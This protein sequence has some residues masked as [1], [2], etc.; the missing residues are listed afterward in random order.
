[1]P[2]LVLAATLNLHL[3][4][5]A[6]S[7]PAL[8]YLLPPTIFAPSRTRVWP[9]S[10]NFLLASPLRHDLPPRSKHLHDIPAVP[11]FSALEHSSLH[12]VAAESRHPIKLS[13]HIRLYSTMV[14]MGLDGV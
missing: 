5:T 14:A 2:L 3:L 13:R 1:M 7:R 11:W 10:R 6:L 12:L 4:R 8:P 9:V